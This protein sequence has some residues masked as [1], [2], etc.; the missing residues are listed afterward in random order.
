MDGVASSPYSIIIYIR[1][2]IYKYI[3]IYIYVIIIIFIIS[4]IMLFLLYHYLYYVIYIYIYM[5]LWFY[6]EAKCV[7]IRPSWKRAHRRLQKPHT[8]YPGFY[9]T[10][11]TYEIVPLKRHEFVMTA[12]I[13][14]L[15]T[16][17][18]FSVKQ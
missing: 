5:L 7:S 18:S 10:T 4:V 14:P 17:S 6:C 12:W 8:I 3:Y 15:Q 2:Y 9:Y 11:N 13:R 1:I 16:S